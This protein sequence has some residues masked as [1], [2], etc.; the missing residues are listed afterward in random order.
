MR[1]GLLYMGMPLYGI[2]DFSPRYVT[3]RNQME[4]L[5]NA[6][7][8]VMYWLIGGPGSFLFLIC[9]FGYGG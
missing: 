8:R 1:T 3:P 5:G 9:A 4:K 7:D 6:F 2:D